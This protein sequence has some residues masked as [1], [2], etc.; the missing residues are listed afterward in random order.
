MLIYMAYSVTS[1]FA[2][3]R[4]IG[5]ALL[6]APILLMWIPS[7]YF[8]KWLRNKYYSTNTRDLS[9][10]GCTIISILLIILGTWYGKMYPDIGKLGS[11]A[12]V[13]LMW[14]PCSLLSLGIW[15][16][17]LSGYIKMRILS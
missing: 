12:T 16:G 13:N 10:F 8:F 15:S 11:S 2:A 4:S 7:H 5:E 6:F 9:I 1:Y 3:S 17:F 14:I